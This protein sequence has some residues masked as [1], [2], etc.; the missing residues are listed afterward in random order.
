MKIIDKKVEN[1]IWNK[2]YNDYKFDPSIDISVLPFKLPMTHK[3]YKLDSY[4][5]KEQEKI[6]N[7]IFKEIATKEIYA[8]DWQHDCFEFNPNEDIEYGYNYYDKERK[9]N[10]YFPSYYPDGDYHFFIS[11][12]WN[13]GMLTHPWRKEIY[14]FG[15]LLIEKINNKTNELNLIEIKTKTEDL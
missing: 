10:V 9:C 14:I 6:V 2:I 12:D 15:D 4:W 8:L 7:D 13:Y 1:K 3:K 11:K 5:N